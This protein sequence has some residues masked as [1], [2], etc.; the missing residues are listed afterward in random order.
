M[1]EPAAGPPDRAR[2]RPC[3][4]PPVERPSLN[5]RGPLAC[6]R[7]ALTCPTSGAS[8]WPAT[9]GP[10]RRRWPSICCSRRAPWPAWA[11]STTARAAL[12][13]EPEEQKR[14]ESLSAA[15]ATFDDDGTIVTLVDTPGY[16][17][18]VAEVIS[19]MAACDGAL[20]VVDASGGVE[21]GLETAVAQA[22]AWGRP[23]CFFINKGDRENA[24]PTAALDALRAAFGQQ[25]RAAPAGDRRGRVVQRLRRPRPP[26]GLAV[27][28]QAGGRDPDPGRARGRGRPAAGPAPRGRRRGRRRRP[29]Q[30]P[31]GRGDQRPRA[32]GVPPQGRQGL[33]PRPGARRQRD[34]GDRAA[35]AARRVHPLPARR[36]STSRRSRRASRR[37]ATRSRSRP[38]RPG[39]SSSGC[40]RR[41]PIRTSAG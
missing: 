18:F 28:R 10:A 33:D 36:R 11:R 19:G 37:R 38:T 32:R 9:P 1:A 22:R 34:Q 40:S 20:L 23:A 27:G 41:R 35:R 29:D 15:V 5:Q 6:R 7:R 4:P 21:A 39:R 2:S 17:D 12:D 30:V 31:R 24:D 16:P 3:R 25:D 8:S 13:F 26:Q 14:H